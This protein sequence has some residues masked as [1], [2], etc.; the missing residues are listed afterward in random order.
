[1]S[2]EEIISLEKKIDGNWKQPNPD[3][4]FNFCVRGIIGRQLWPSMLS[5]DMMTDCYPPSINLHTQYMLDLQEH[6]KQDKITECTSL[7]NRGNHT[8]V[9]IFENCIGW[10]KRL[11]ELS[12]RSYIPSR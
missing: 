10:T 12:G 1:M 4:T 3:E 7:A 11:R 5:Q 8:D 6:N 9:V 2:M